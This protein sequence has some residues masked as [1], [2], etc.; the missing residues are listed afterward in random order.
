MC[1]HPARPA[2]PRPGARLAVA[3]EDLTSDG[4]GVARHEGWVLFVP[5]A[6]PGDRAEVRAGRARRGVVESTLL[7][8]EQRSPDRVAPP[9][10]LQAACG[11]C[12]L[13]VLG[14]E[15]QLALK[16]RHLAETLRRIGGWGAPRIAPVVAAPS[17]LRYRGRVRFAVAPRDGGPAIGFHP[18]GV[19]GGIVTVEDCLLAPEPSSR[20]A[21]LL[22]TRLDALSP[23]GAWWPR[24][25]ES[26]HSFAERRGMLVLFGPPGPAPAAARA[27]RE[28][29]ADEPAVAGVVRV[30]GAP[31]R[32]GRETLLAGAAELVERIGGVEFELGATT[33]LQVHPAAAEALYVEVRR[34]L[35]R[36]GSAPRRLLD[37]FCGAGAIGLLAA[38]PECEV[39]GIESHPA[40]VERARRSARRAGR[41]RAVFRA[42]DARS[43]A[44]ELARAGERFELVT[45][46]PPRAGLGPALPEAIAALAPR[47][48]VLVSCHPA[49]LARDLRAFAAQGFE[50][51]EIAAVDLFPQTPHLE[52]VARLVPRGEAS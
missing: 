10:S 15:A 18:R 5:G 30:E 35:E 9:C 34:L 31:G 19:G 43:A 17:E 12:P 21:R 49:T 3:I 36:S 27:A 23:S 37:L 42:A 44:E 38:G 47:A 50:P 8:L 32:G 46:N 1:P 26:R 20:W 48:V 6:V 24:E 7:G 11:G 22:V 45:A 16:V 28:L 40:T 52:A 2:P 14:P 33:F 25:I 41:S 39:L 51:A 4:A 29:V 13:M